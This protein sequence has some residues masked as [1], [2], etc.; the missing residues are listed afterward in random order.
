MP[1]TPP[2][3][4]S[5]DPPDSW[6][7]SPSPWSVSRLREAEACALRVAL[8]SANYPAIWERRGY[9]PK[10]ALPA[11]IGEVVHEAISRIVTE[12]RSRGCSSTRDPAAIAAISELGGFTRMAEQAAAQVLARNDDNPRFF[13]HRE[14]AVRAICGQIPE[15]RR[16]VQ[17]LLCEM[18]LGPSRARLRKCMGGAMGP[19]S[20]GVYSEVWLEVPELDLAGRADQIVVAQSGAEITEFKAGE[21]DSSHRFQLQVYALLWTRDRRLNPS[22]HLP[23]SLRLRYLNRSLEVPVPSVPEL[24]KLALELASRR[25]NAVSALNARPPVARY[26]PAACRR[27]DVR[28]LCSEYWR[29]CEKCGSMARPNE[30]GDVE[31]TV[32]GR[33]GDLSF[34]VRVERANGVP[35]GKRAL[36]RFR[37]CR[38][39]HK[40]DRL[41]VLDAALAMDED[42]AN[43]VLIVRISAFTEVFRV[44]G[45]H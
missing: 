28:Q 41:R 36:I 5:V 7:A 21:A 4:W 34:D 31:V 33:H 32:L 26:D 1:T 20:A 12:L 43:P 17:S 3:L 27:C 6:P 37:D 22:G 38:E 15:I 18:K 24:E 2:A 44:S 13:P 19:L 16:R 10:F 45:T 8:R 29:T 9:P 23:T 40:G 25:S 11:L 14:Y 35:P 39:F 30:W 42:E